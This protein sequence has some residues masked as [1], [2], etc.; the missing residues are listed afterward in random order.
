MASP[1]PLGVT[2]LCTPLWCCA[3]SRTCSACRFWLASGTWRASLRMAAPRALRAAARRRSSKA[4]SLCLRLQVTF[5]WRLLAN[6]W[7]TVSARWLEVRGVPNC[8]AA[9][10]KVL[11]TGWG[12]ILVYMAS[13]APTARARPPSARS[14]SGVTSRWRHLRA[15]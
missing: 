9:I 4:A 7:A 8:L 10:S 1:A 12:Q 5:P 3:R 15:G 2:G 11:A 14:C 13:H 6:C